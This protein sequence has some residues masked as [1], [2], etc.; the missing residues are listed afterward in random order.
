M[1]SWLQFEDKD[2]QGL[3]ESSMQSFNC[4]GALPDLMVQEVKRIV[5]IS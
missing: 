5:N 2:K 1:Y 3:S 4:K